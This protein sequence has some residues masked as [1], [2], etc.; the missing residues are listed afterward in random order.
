MQNKSNARIIQGGLVQTTTITSNNE[1]HT[2]TRAQT[3]QE[4]INNIERLLREF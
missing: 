3:K 2:S 4:L 1:K